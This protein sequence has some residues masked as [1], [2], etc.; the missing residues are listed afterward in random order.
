MKILKAALLL[1]ALLLVTACSFYEARPKLNYY[2]GPN[3]PEGYIK[4]VRATVGE[5]EFEIQVEFAERKL[6]H[7]I[8]DGNDPVAEGWYPTTRA[9]LQFYT[10]ALKPR[11]GQ[12]FE[13]GKT[14]R[15]C[16]GQQNPEAVQLTSSNYQCMVDFTFV[17]E[18]KS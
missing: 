10:V 6:Y 9:G 12:Q 7:L 18:E 1:T 11:K 5:I 4:V 15:L 2:H 17:F 3:V 8:L 14:Y 13:I 16:I